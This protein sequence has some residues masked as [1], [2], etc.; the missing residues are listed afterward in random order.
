MLWSWVFLLAGPVYVFVQL[1]AIAVTRG[2]WRLASLAPLALV[3]MAAWQAF[4]ALTDRDD[5]FVSILIGAAPVGLLWLAGVLMLHRLFARRVSA[6][7]R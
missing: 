4:R 7:S 3:V 1:V 6:E 2:W 5:Y